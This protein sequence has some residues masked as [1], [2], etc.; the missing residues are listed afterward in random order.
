MWQE[1]E[2]RYA[3]SIF[4]FCLKNAC[5][6]ISTAS[7]PLHRARQ[8]FQYYLKNKQSFDTN[9]G[10]V[11]WTSFLTFLI[12]F[13]LFRWFCNFSTWRKYAGFCSV[14]NCKFTKRLLTFT[15]NLLLLFIWYSF[16][17]DYW[18]YFKY[19]YIFMR[20]CGAIS[21]F[22]IACGWSM[23]GLLLWVVNTYCS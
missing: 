19:M 4:Q 7:F 9:C 16:V 18:P 17:I 21:R 14:E 2:I 22:I 6:P 13:L 15:L 12:H 10:N 11:T 23:I 20:V 5:L 8:S 3:F 1:T